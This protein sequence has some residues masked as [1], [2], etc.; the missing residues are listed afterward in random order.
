MQTVDTATHSISDMPKRAK[1]P[2]KPLNE[3]DLGD[4]YFISL[5]EEA[6]KS[7]RVSLE[8]VMEVLEQ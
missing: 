1:T 3:R 4:A 7:E 5:I 8:E 6:V 2:V